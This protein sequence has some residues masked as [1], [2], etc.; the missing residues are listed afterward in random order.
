MD[1]GDDRGL[2]AGQAEAQIA[3]MHERA[4]EIDGAR[5][6]LCCVSADDRAARIP[7]AERLGNLVERFPHR[8]V[9]RRAERFVVRPVLHMHEHR[10]PA[11]H[12][13]NDH[14]RSDCGIGD[15]VGVQM[16]FE[17]IDRDKRNP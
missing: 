15:L 8:I 4:G 12:E 7:K 14:R 6:A 9:D 13:R 2:Q 3:R 11:A 1:I 5:I 10:V 16:A 17:M